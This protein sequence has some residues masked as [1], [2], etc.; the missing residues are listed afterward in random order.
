MDNIAATV[1]IVRSCHSEI[2]SDSLSVYRTCLKTAHDLGGLSIPVE[3][4]HSESSDCKDNSPDS[5]NLDRVCTRLSSEL[6]RNKELSIFKY[7]SVDEGH[8]YKQCFVQM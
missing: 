3:K 2:F 1:D 5:S 7:I 8:L 4:K 6:K